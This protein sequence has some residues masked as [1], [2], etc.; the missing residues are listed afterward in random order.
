MVHPT[1]KMRSHPFS[2]L[3]PGLCRSCAELQTRH[4]EIV[5]A[6]VEAV[7]LALVAEEV[8][9]EA[10]SQRGSRLPVRFDGV[11]DEARPLPS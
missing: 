11:E 4:V 8:H 5:P 7:A 6:A 9:R 2:C 3:L 10:A 1:A